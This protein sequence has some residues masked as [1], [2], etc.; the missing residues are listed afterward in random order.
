[1]SDTTQEEEPT[2]ETVLALLTVYTDQQWKDGIYL[3]MELDGKPVNMQMDIGVSLI[4][5]GL[6]KDKLKECPLQPAYIHPPF[7]HTLVTLFLC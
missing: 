4:P 2:V 5:E 3:N 1:M 6:Y 7:L